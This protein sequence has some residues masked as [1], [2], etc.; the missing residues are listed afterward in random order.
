MHVQVK[1]MPTTRMAPGPACQADWDLQF[2]HDSTSH[3]ARVRNMPDMSAFTLTFFV[4]SASNRTTQYLVS[5]Y[6]DVN[7]NMIVVRTNT[8]QVTVHGSAV[9]LSSINLHDGA[10]HHVAITW[11]RATNQS[12]VFFDGA[13]VNQR[14]VAGTTISGAG[15]VFLLGQ[16]QDAGGSLDASQIFSPGRANQVRRWA[17]R[18]IDVMRLGKSS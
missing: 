15:G 9:S 8:F 13:V 16:E 7:Q 4:N 3:Y 17:G 6:T 14:T 18:G 1:V 11:T 5:Y 2:T 12:L 10:W